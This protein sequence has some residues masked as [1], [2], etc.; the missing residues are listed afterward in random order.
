M[1]FLQTP[2]DLTPVERSRA[3]VRMAQPDLTASVRHEDVEAAGWAPTGDLE[4]D[5]ARWCELYDLVVA[6]KCARWLQETPNH[7]GAR[8][9]RA[10]VER[11]RARRRAA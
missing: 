5:L 11:H 6:R 9:W 1:S 2:A 7:P 3:Y 4:T 8:A 10:A